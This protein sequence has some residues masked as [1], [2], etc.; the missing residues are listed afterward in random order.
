MAASEQ[1][2]A[3]LLAGLVDNTA[4]NIGADDV[5][6][7][8]LQT[9]V[10]AVYFNDPNAPV[11]LTANIAEQKFVGF[12]GASAFGHTAISPNAA[13]DELDITI[14]GDYLLTLNLSCEPENGQRVAFGIAVDNVTT[15]IASAIGKAES[16]SAVVPMSVTVPVP[17]TAGQNVSVRYLANA[18]GTSVDVLAISLCA[19]RVR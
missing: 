16:N 17:L 15:P 2:E 10:G 13:S 5:G 6:S 3:A 18:N 8:V 7:L 12:V 1:S 19:T 11:G 4:G 14:D 9:A